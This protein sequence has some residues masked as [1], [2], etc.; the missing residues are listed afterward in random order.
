MVEPDTIATTAGGPRPALVCF[1]HRP[2]RGVLRLLRP[3][4]RH[5]F[6][7]LREADAWLVCDPLKGGLVLEILPGW[8]TEALAGHY[9]ATGR[10]VA[11]GTARRGGAV[12]GTGLRLLSCVEVVKRAIGVAAAGVLTPRQLFRRLVEIEGWSGH[13][14]GCEE[15]V[16]I[17]LG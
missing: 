12:A 3:G 5:C 7:L 11:V 14:P 17:V 9:L 6:C 16:D 8:P 4:F 1:E 10:H 15:L 13:V 2:G